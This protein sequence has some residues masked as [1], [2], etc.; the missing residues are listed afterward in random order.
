MLKILVSDDVILFIEHVVSFCACAMD[1]TTYFK[2]AEV[3]QLPGEKCFKVA[4]LLILHILSE[5]R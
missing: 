2:R 3:V 4:V 1:I 5:L